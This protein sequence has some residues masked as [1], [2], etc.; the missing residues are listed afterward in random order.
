MQEAI[1][2]GCETTLFLLI[3]NRSERLVPFGC[4]GDHK[5]WLCCQRVSFSPIFWG[6]LAILKYEILKEFD[7][8]IT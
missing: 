3:V 1:P 2:R 5:L 8:T 6:E 4:E 7:D